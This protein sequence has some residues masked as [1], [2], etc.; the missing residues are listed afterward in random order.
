MTGPYNSAYGAYKYQSAES[1]TLGSITPES[2][3]YRDQAKLLTQ[4]TGDVSY[5]SAYMRKMQQGIDDANQNFVQQIQS[6]INDL[7][8]IF[9]GGSGDTGFEWGDFGYLLQMVG[10]LFGFDS[11][12]GLPDNATVAAGY[13]ISQYFL[14]NESWQEVIDYSVDN[15]IAGAISIFG[16]VPILGQA[17]EQLGVIMSQMRDTNYTINTVLNQFF[18]AFGITPDHPT[19]TWSDF[20][21][22]IFNLYNGLASLFS[23]TNYGEFQPVWEQMQRWDQQVMDAIIKLVNGDLSGLIGLIPIS[24]LTNIA[25]DLQIESDFSNPDCIAENDEG[26]VHDPT[27]GRNG[28]GSAKLVTDGSQKA[29]KGSPITT[30]EGDI[31]APE[32]WVRWSGLSGSGVQIKLQLRLSNGTDHDLDSLSNLSANGGWVKLSG[33]MPITAG[34]TRV[35]PRICVTSGVGAGATIWLDDAPDY[36]QGDNV[37]PEDWI[38][39][40]TQKWNGFLELFGIDVDEL[41]NP[42]PNWFWNMI[43][44]SI[45]KPMDEFA[46]ASG[47]N[48]LVD[49]IVSALTG[50]TNQHFME[51]VWDALTTIPEVNVVGLPDIT[52]NVNK[53]LEP[54]ANI[55]GGSL[56][57]STAWS[58][59]WD[60]LMGLLGIDTHALATGTAP[61]TLPLGAIPNNIPQNYIS[62]LTSALN[63][64]ITTGDW[65]PLLN[66][67]FGTSSVQSTLHVD[68]VPTG[69]PQNRITGLPTMNDILGQL[70]ELFS[71]GT[72]STPTD[73]I[74]DAVDWFND[75]FGFRTDTTQTAQYQQSFQISALTGGYRNPTWV[76]RYPIG[77]VTFPETML[78]ATTVV[79][80]DTGQVENKISAPIPVYLHQGDS[81]GGIVTTSN[82][83]IYDTVAISILRQTTDPDTGDPVGVPNNIFLEIFRISSTN[84]ATRINVEDISNLMTTPNIVTYLERPLNPPIIAQA[85]E[86]YVVRVRNSSTVATAIALTVLWQRV[87]AAPA[88][89]LT[90]STYPN[91]PATNQTTYSAA[92]LTSAMRTSGDIAN[93]MGFAALATVNPA[94]TDRL[95]SDDFNRLSLGSLWYTKSD[96]AGNITIFLGSSAAYGGSASGAQQALYTL[97]LASDR[98]SSSCNL[99]G[100]GLS[101]GGARSGVMICCNRDMSQIVFLGVNNTTA[102]ILTGALGSALS[103]RA[104]ISSSGNDVNWEIRYDPATNKFTVYKAGKLTTLSWTD[105]SNIINHGENY[106]FGGLRIERL[107][108]YNGAAVDNWVLRDWA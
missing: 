4:L 8:V 90:S 106:K 92:E 93:R 44:N 88:S 99:G 9:G 42:D 101:L 48:N 26:W 27:V 11:E 79:S 29:L 23:D 56:G 5:M 69:M 55:F 53:M 28:A 50:G 98:M 62:G 19:N 67:L 43:V 70:G 80:L 57:S 24:Q 25:P 22:A 45:I 13:F 7:T 72:V 73:W 85:G 76:S 46:E 83:T 35:W 38:Q 47:F 58:D 75:L 51:D 54:F 78:S 52:A 41:M 17:V 15:S 1:R 33:S 77:D 49:T 94:T 65:T 86:R 89:W 3:D 12:T 32:V 20:F 34:T 81:R 68:V 104:S 60:G 14:S 74:S 102:S 30:H 103:Q 37:I 66:A 95:Y 40:L 21:N 10:A 36:K 107:S 16:E 39:S 100:T 63:N 61:A 82:P 96:N 18:S 31:I 6:L 71:G 105:S 84:V 59:A 64:A 97:P 108:G 91:R 87:D 2:F